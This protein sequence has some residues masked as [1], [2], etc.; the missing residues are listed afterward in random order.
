MNTTIK[1]LGNN[2]NYIQL[3]PKTT[4][5]NV[6]GWELGELFGPYQITL[7]AS[8]WNAD[9]QQTVSLPGI[10]QEDIPYCVKVLTGSQQQMMAQISAYNLLDPIAGLESLDGELRFTCSESVPNVDLTVQVDW[11]R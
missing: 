3:H 9:R 11:I 5:E 8:R 4:K 2:N 10:T 6:N 1:V 7:Y